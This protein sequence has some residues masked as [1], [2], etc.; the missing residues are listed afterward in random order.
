M[1]GQSDRCLSVWDFL[2]VK[3]FKKTFPVRFYRCKS[4]RK[5]FVVESM[6]RKPFLIGLFVAAAMVIC[7]CFF[8][9]YVNSA[10]RE[11]K[12]QIFAMDTIMTL[13][14]Y[15][16]GGDEA[17]DS[18]VEEINR[19]DALLSTENSESEVSKINQSGSGTLSAD[20]RE[21]IDRSLD[22]Y[23]ETR[24]L[25]DI[26]IYPV[27]R[28]WGFTDG[29][30]YVPTDQEIS[31]ILKLVDAS[32]IV[33]SGDFAILGEG[34]EIDLGGIAKGYTSKRIIDIFRDYYGVKSAMVSLGG[35]VQTLG[36]K[37]DGSKWEIGIQDPSRPRGELI[38]SLS[39]E[40]KAVITSGGY[41]RYFEED[42]Q[43]YI[44]IMDPRTARPAKSD[45]LSVT[46]ISD[47]GE[48]ADALSTS[49]FIMGLAG[50][51]DFWR[52]HQRD[53]E[54]VLIDKDGQIYVTDAFKDNL[55]TDRE[56]KIIE[57]S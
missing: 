37:P 48:M 11:Y 23:Q 18:A 56:T 8:H 54:M 52:A 6:D 24:G 9:Y 41:E 46:I 38:G 4:D 16:P 32:S 1:S 29:E 15:G 51:Q 47:D 2:I 5:D 35:N 30:Y 19:I 44:H 33:L 22:I 28:L 20:T 14:A 21:I 25:F 43:T 36:V 31:E 40:D 42:G 55:H 13:T 26:T 7:G 12:R 57:G 45:L 34:Q 49:L 3:L 10:R 53:F 17:L 27:M 50:A 39:V